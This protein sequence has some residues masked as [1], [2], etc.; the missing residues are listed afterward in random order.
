MSGRNIFYQQDTFTEAFQQIPCIYFSAYPIRKLNFINPPIGFVRKTL[1][2]SFPILRECAWQGLGASRSM[3]TCT[4][5]QPS[6]TQAPMSP[7]TSLLQPRH[8]YMQEG[9]DLCSKID[10]LTILV[11]IIEIFIFQ[12]LNDHKAHIINICIFLSL[13]AN[14]R[15]FIKMYFL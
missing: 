15:F 12:F 6:E 4:L 7:E 9:V 11:L 1:T 5:G 14:Y 8:A 3:T 13:F 10:F 2:G